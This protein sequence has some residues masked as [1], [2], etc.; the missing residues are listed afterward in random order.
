MEIISR[1]DG[2]TRFEPKTDKQA[3][4]LPENLKNNH[5]K[6]LEMFR[7]MND[8]PAQGGSFLL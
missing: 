1:Q 3:G 4:Y 8:V 2:S 5:K 7:L 6:F